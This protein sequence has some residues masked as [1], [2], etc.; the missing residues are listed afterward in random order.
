MSK[1]KLV[2]KLDL[3]CDRDK[4]KVFKKLSCFSGIDSIAVDM[5]E[6]K[7]TVV[8]TADLVK[9]VCK[10]RKCWDVEMVSVGPLAKEND[11]ECGSGG[12]GKGGGGG[13]GGR[14]KKKDPNEENLELLRSAQVCNKRCNTTFYIVNTT[15]ENPSSCVIF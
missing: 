14:E 13:G 5:K 4:R 3:H 8:G 11:R 9:V 15:E 12:G 2:A 10:L 7:L 1:Q 6:K